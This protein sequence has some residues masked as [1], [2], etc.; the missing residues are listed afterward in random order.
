MNFKRSGWFG[1]GLGAV[2]RGYPGEAWLKAV[3]NAINKII[4]RG[5]VDPDQVGGG[6]ATA[7][8]RPTS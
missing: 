2:R 7:D 6:R 4:N 8:M 3:P 1:F 5:L